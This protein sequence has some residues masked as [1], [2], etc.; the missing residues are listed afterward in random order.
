MQHPRDPY[1]C[2]KRLGC[3]HTARH[4]VHPAIHTDA[5]PHQPLESRPKIQTGR[6]TNLRNKVNIHQ[7]GCR[8]AD[9]VLSCTKALQINHVITAQAVPTQLTLCFRVNTGKLAVV[10]PWLVENTPAG[11]GLG[12]GKRARCQAEQTEVALT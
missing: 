9:W 5:P 1:S 3:L 8:D 4:Q 11:F 7:K 6:F 12:G 10:Q 2:V